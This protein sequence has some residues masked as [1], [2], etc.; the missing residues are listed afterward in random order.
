[1][2]TINHGWSAVIGIAAF[3]T[4]WNCVEKQSTVITITTIWAVSDIF[5]GV[6]IVIATFWTVWICALMFYGPGRMLW[7]LSYTETV[8]SLCWY[9]VA[10]GRTAQSWSCARMAHSQIARKC[11]LYHI[12]WTFWISMLM[13]FGQEKCLSTRSSRTLWTVRCCVVMSHNR[14]T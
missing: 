9:H 5:L 4:V 3:W 13:S 6:V 11:N 10:S 2:C 14:R 12:L 1:M 8:W 7:W